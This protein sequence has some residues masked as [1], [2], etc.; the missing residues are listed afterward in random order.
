VCDWS[1]KV[2]VSFKK[3]KKSKK[4]MSGRKSSSAS[5]PSNK[6]TL[7]CAEEELSSSPPEIEQ[8]RSV[9][10]NVQAFNLDVNTNAFKY[11]YS[12]TTGHNVDFYLKHSVTTRENGK[13]MVVVG[14]SFVGV[15]AK[16]IA[17]H[18]PTTKSGNGELFYHSPEIIPKLIYNSSKQAFEL[19][20][21]LQSQI[22][23]NFVVSLAFKISDPDRFCYVFSCKT[24]SAPYNNTILLPM[25]MFDN[26]RIALNL[27]KSHKPKASLHLFVRADQIVV[28]VAEIWKGHLSSTQAESDATES[29]KMSKLIASALRGKPKPTLLSEQQNQFLLATENFCT[30]E[31]NE[32]NSNLLNTL[33]PKNEIA[34]EDKSKENQVQKSKTETK[35]KRRKKTKPMTDQTPTSSQPENNFS[36]IIPISSFEEYS[37]QQTNDVIPT[38][39]TLIYE[40]LEEP[41]P[42]PFNSDDNLS[43]DLFGDNSLLSTYNASEDNNLINSDGDTSELYRVQTNDLSNSIPSSDIDLE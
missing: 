9:S 37:S 7:E 33:M 22:P 12:R 27:D 24:L 21:E 19:K 14:K 26:P 8:A 29:S 32:K 39:S 6:R 38:T 43:Y 13:A 16:L 4:K 31:H 30:N 35:R 40:P 42:L 25:K 3:T 20:I 15:K 2:I 10:Y 41:I 11:K 1:R 34:E 23:M 17:A 18:L 28:H 36:S 5:T